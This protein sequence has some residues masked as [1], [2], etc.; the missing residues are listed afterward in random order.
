MQEG[1]PAHL[2]HLLVALLHRAISLVKVGTVAVLVAQQLHFDV[3]T[4]FQELLKPTA[5][6]WMRTAQHC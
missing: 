3:P 5:M 2:D 4:I 6:N 1:W